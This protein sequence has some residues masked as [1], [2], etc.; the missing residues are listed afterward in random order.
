MKHASLTSPSSTVFLAQF[1]AAPVLADIEQAS[2]LGFHT[3]LESSLFR[4]LL[5]V[6]LPSLLNHRFT[7]ES[8]PE[9]PIKK[10][11]YPCWTHCTFNSL[12][13]FFLVIMTLFIFI[14]INIFVCLSVIF[15]VTTYNVSSM[16]AEIFSVLVLW[17]H[18]L[19]KYLE[20][21]NRVV[22]IVA[23]S[24]QSVSRLW[25]TAVSKSGGTA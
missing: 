3:C 2:L 17:H 15:C 22:N 13:F 5:A 7:L 14:N 20:P 24:H 4:Y 16:R 1:A 10:K 25:W 12:L 23:S 21:G 19:E 8:W 11:N 9:I 6:S 18:R